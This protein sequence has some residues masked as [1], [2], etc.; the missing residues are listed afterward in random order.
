M[1]VYR[2]S[3]QNNNFQYLAFRKKNVANGLG[4]GGKVDHFG[5]WIDED[6]VNGESN[7]K[8]S[9][10]SNAPRLSARKNFIIMH[11]EVWGF[12]IISKQSSSAKSRRMSSILREI[13]ATNLDASSVFG[14]TGKTYH[15]QN[16]PEY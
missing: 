3:G 8:C 13:S 10:F 7:T 2:S 9:T 6:G 14:L 5:L 16:Y 15:S 1:K 11:L 12:G 4:F